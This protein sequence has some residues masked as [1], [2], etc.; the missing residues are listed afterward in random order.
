MERIGVA[1]SEARSAMIDKKFYDQLKLK[2]A[3]F[4]FITTVVKYVRTVLH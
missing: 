1:L 2:Y 4:A 3:V